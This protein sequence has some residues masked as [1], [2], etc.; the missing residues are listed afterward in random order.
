MP[1]QETKEKKETTMS[2]FKIGDRVAVYNNGQRYIGIVCDDS[3]EGIDQI[4]VKAGNGPSYIVHKNQLR[5]LVKKER[6]RVWV[7][8]RYIDQSYKLPDIVCLEAT[9][10]N[11]HDSQWTEFVEVRRKK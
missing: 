10:V 8:T 6:R 4:P 2:K 1:C 9:E 7:R 3:V 5:K 11:P